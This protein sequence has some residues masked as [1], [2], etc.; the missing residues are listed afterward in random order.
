MTAYKL[1]K[2]YTSLLVLIYSVFVYSIF[3]IL[4]AAYTMS[5]G[6]LCVREM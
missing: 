5:R 6:K 2:D 3:H 1:D 4:S